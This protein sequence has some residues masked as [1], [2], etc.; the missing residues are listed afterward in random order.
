MKGFCMVR[1]GDGSYMA[2][3]L[4]EGS[5]PRIGQP[6]PEEYDEP[7]GAIVLGVFHERTRAARLLDVISALD[8]LEEEGE[9]TAA[10]S[11][12]L[13]ELYQAEKAFPRS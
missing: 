11:D 9:I 12:I 5:E 2:I 4:M 7:E 8:R 3:E 13:E 6:L 1:Y 10:F